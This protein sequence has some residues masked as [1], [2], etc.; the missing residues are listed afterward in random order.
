MNSFSADLKKEG[1]TLIITL[2]GR[3]DED[4]RYPSINDERYD[5][6]VFVLSDVNMINS[7]GIRDWLAWHKTIV[8]RPQIVFKECHKLIIDQ[9][10]MVAG[11]L[12]ENAIVQSFYT[13]Y[14]CEKCEKLTELFLEREKD[15]PQGDLDLPEEIE[16]MHCKNKA[17]LD[18]IET[19]YLKFIR[20]RKNT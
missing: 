13:P 11:F 14:Y 17:E 20:R 16:C 19:K 4:V 5:R 1:N 18:V 8:G 10:N 12:P 7:C 6:L 9:V 15:Y 3:L 2:K